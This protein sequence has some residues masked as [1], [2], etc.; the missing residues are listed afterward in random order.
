MFDITGLQ[1]RIILS[2]EEWRYFYGHLKKKKCF[3]FQYLFD[4][5][6]L[7]DRI[8]VSLE[9]HDVK[10]RE[11]MLGNMNNIGFHIMKVALSFLMPLLCRF[12]LCVCGCVWVCDGVCVCVWLWHGVC[13]CVCVCVCDTLINCFT[14][15]WS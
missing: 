14:S 15:M 11:A 9:Q 12:Q 10:G 4:I 13:V 1:D 2:F 8:M 5:T 3:H 7:Q 6:G